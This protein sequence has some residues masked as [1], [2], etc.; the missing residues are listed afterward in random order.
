[1]QQKIQEFEQLSLTFDKT[2]WTV[3]AFN[4]LLTCFIVGG[5]FYYAWDERWPELI[6]LTLLWYFGSRLTGALLSISTG[7]S[8]VALVL[9]TLGALNVMFGF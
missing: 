1:M 7:L 2:A 4:V 3:A 5:M 9:T 6:K 8:L